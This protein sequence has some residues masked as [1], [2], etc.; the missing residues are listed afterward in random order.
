MPRITPLEPPYAPDLQASFDAVM[1]GA[2]PLTLFRSIAVSPRAWKKF[3]AGALLDSGPLSLRERE[4]IIDR[5]CALSGC[6]YEWGV[7]VAVFAEP[8]GLTAAE[9][10]APAGQGDAGRWAAPERALIRT[11]EAL[12]ARATLNDEEFAELSA[13][14]DA[15]QILEVLMLCGFYRMVAYVAN[16][17]ALPGEPGAARLPS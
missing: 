12:H 9:V 1:R 13:H 15:E 2:P 14:Y 16:G 6:E 7:H 17:L 10:A 8:A 5:T 11:A 3:R 4:I